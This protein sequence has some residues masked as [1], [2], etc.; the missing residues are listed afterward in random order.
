MA[1]DAIRGFLPTSA[2]YKCLLPATQLASGDKS[3]AVP[4]GDKDWLVGVLQALGVDLQKDDGGG[5]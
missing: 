3:V 4:V 2:F 1:G 5:Q